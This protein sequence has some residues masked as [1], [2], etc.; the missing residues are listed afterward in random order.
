MIRTKTSGAGTRL[1]ATRLIAIAALTL[2]TAGAAAAAAEVSLESG[3]IKFESEDGKFAAQIG[4]RI[5]QDWAFVKANDDA[6]E[7]LGLSSTDGAELRRGRFAIQG[8]FYG[9]VVYKAEWDFVGGK[10]EAKD[11]YFELTGLPVGAVRVGHF[12]EPFSLDELTS[13]KYS[14]FME[15]GLTSSFVPSRNMGLALRNQIGQDARGTWSV[16]VFREETDSRPVGVSI[17][18]AVYA[19]TG[20]VTFLPQYAEEGKKLIHVGLGL[21]HRRPPSKMESYALRP[22]SHLAPVMLESG[23]FSAERALLVDAE[24]AM[25]SGPLS[26]QGEFLAASHTGED[27]GDADVDND[28]M[29]TSFYA[30]VGYFVTGESKVYKTKDGVFDRVKPA[31]N[32][33][34]GEGAMGAL[35]LAAR[36]SMADLDDEDNGVGGGTLSDITVGANWHLNPNTR[37]M[38]NYVMASASDV[39]Y[40]TAPAEAEGGV[41]I[42]QTR[43]QVEF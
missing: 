23:G 33:G 31:R 6:K 41:Q 8:K 19:E 14:T 39:G 28:P 17:E 2:G 37:V 9:N 13:S 29:F 42:L 1:T 3:L 22:E 35:E 10:T 38:V 20:R 24:A 5:Q 15:R 18:P 36:F 25:V 7:Q 30:Q 4:G 40:E 34:D 43:F 27:I 26:L 16:G 12:F 21:S 11:V 32:F